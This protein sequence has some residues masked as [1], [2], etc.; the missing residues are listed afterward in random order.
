M[1]FKLIVTSRATIKPDKSLPHKTQL[2]VLIEE[3]LK[4]PC[5]GID[6]LGER[7]INGNTPDKFLVKKTTSRC[8][9]KKSNEPRKSSGSKYINKYFCSSK[10]ILTIKEERKRRKEGGRNSNN[11]SLV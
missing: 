4:Q 1:F 2:F 6:V 10:L 11:K 8:S 5:Q 3:Q 7:K 9:L